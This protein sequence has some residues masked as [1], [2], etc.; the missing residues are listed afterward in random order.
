MVEKQSGNIL[1]YFFDECVYTADQNSGIFRRESGGQQFYQWLAT[2]FAGSKIRCNAIAPGFLVSNQN[3]A[4]LF[5]ENGQPTA[6]SQ[7]ILAGT[8][9][10]RFVESNELLGGV[11][12]LCDD[13]AASAV[14]G[15][16]LPIDAGF[17]AYS[18]YKI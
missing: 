13:R 3:R 16:V 6:R 7:K 17:S 14:T 10:G 4:L 8:P 12:F 5:D 15:V 18:G 2:H 9:A 11:F 1:K